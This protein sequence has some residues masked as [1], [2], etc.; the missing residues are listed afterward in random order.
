MDWRKEAKC[1]KLFLLSDSEIVGKTRREINAENTRRIHDLFFPIQGDLDSAKE[2]MRICNEECPVREE[3]LREALE[4]EEKIGIW[5]GTS[6]R[7][8]RRLSRMRH[9]VAISR[10]FETQD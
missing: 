4:N 1:K 3:C 6:G 8:R 2:A 10:T 5:G 7:T 9:I